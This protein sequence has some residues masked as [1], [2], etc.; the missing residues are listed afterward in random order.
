MA[1]YILSID[2]GGVRGIIAATILQA[3]QKKINK[4]IANIFDLIAGSSVGSLI[5][6]ALCIKDHNGE[7][8]YN[9][10]D[11]LDILL[12]SSGRIFNQSMI[13][14]LFL[15]LLGQCILIRI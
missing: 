13:K 5:G 11:I 12:N 9:T 7:H 6:A 10:S 1:R 4:P 14:K 8:K 3:I 15:W 2:G